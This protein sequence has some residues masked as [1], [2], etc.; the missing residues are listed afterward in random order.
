MRR[1]R[2][3]SRATVLWGVLA[4][5]LVQ[6]GTMAAIEC[7]FPR[8]RDPAYG[9]RLSR[10]R[11]RIADAPESFKVVVL[12]S[13]RP[14]YGLRGKLLEEPLSLRIGRPVVAAN[15]A[16][17]GAGCV[18]ELLTLKRLLADGVRPDM[19]IIEVLPVFLAKQLPL[20]VGAADE[21]RFPIKRLRHLDLT[22]IE[23]YAGPPRDNLRQNWWIASLMPLHTHR[24]NLIG[25]FWPTLL[26]EARERTIRDYERTDESGCLPLWWPKLPDEH[27]RQVNRAKEGFAPYLT[28]YELGGAN[29]IALQE[30]LQ[31]CRT[32]QLTAAML[33]MPEGTEFRKLYSANA[34]TQIDTFL[35]A[36]SHQFQIPMINAR[37]WCPE[38]AFLDSH[39]LHAVGAVSFTD[40]LA[41]EAIPAILYPLPHPPPAP[42]ASSPSSGEL[43]RGVETMLR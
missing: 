24:L 43:A 17:A 41:R 32:H 36:V 10:L 9:C 34:Q 4:F 30:L 11:Q 13:S 15:F 40:R 16:E 23:K 33:I 28:N 37:D 38:D 3:I 8:F 14:E 26:P 6:V 35:A 29:A 12:G 2:G 25:S 39:H 22:L 19:V 21:K 18:E 42:S 1:A 7:H 5:A 31:T 20:P 27:A